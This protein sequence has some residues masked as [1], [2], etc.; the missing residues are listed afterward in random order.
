[1]R[2]G[3]SWFYRLFSLVDGFCGLGSLSTKAL[4]QTVDEVSGAGAVPSPASRRTQLLAAFEQ[5]GLDRENNSFLQQNVGHQPVV[6][7][8]INGLAFMLFPGALNGLTHNG[9]ACAAWIEQHMIGLS[10]MRF[11]LTQAI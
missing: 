9:C 6:I 8:Q 2:Y 4:A 1:M 3:C 10:G 5:S 11:A 7:G